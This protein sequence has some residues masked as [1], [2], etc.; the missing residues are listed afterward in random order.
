MMVNTL[1][2]IELILV[3]LFRADWRR[4][5]VSDMYRQIVYWF[6]DYAREDIPF[7][8]HQFAILGQSYNKPIGEWF[9][10]STLA[11]TLE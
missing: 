6:L 4:S 9:G 2:T 5:H 7:S 10:P 3:S 11:Q 8:I 1:D